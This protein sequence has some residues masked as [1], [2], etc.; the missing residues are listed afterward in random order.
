MEHEKIIK[1]DTRGTIRI[2]VRLWTS[3][4]FKDRHGNEF[5]YDVHVLH[6]PKGNR[7]AVVNDNIATPAEILEAKYE[8]WKRI[9]P[10]STIGKRLNRMRLLN[11]VERCA[12]IL[13]NES[14]Y[15]PGTPGHQLNEDA[16]ALINEMIGN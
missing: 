3:D 8:L 14:N 11:I 16:T 2:V 4:N 15:P 6:T 7:K 12:S 9:E 5:R 10:N 1:D 13:G